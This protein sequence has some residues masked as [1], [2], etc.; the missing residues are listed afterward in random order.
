MD[1][2]TG[3][4]SGWL[5]FAGVMFIVAGALDLLWGIA[6]LANDDFFRADELLF[7]DLSAWGWVYIV[8]GV[9]K[10]GLGAL[11]LARKGFGIVVGALAV[12]INAV[13]A[14]ASLG[15]YPLWSTVVLAIDALILY[16][17][18]VH[19]TPESVDSTQYEPTGRGF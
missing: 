17:L 10:I 5:T 9:V 12:T 11:V 19:G 3:T 6:A 2:T 4:R 18:V 1:Q 13:V 14:M 8:F 15:A 16:G 7:G